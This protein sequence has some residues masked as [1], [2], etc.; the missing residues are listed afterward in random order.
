MAIQLT[1]ESDGEILLVLQKATQG[2]SREEIEAT[3]A[4]PLPLRTLQRTLRRLIEI[5]EITVSG[6][7]RATRYS[8][9]DSETSASPHVGR[10]D[11]LPLSPLAENIRKLV[12]LPLHQRK[13]VGY[14][15]AF[16]ES[17][18]PNQTHYLP[19]KERRRLLEMASS[20]G[21]ELPA[22]T[23]ARQILN[24]LLIDL[25]WNSSRL[26][27]NTYSLLE[28]ERLLQL[29]EIAEGK[30]AREA[31]MIL[32][33]KAAIE[34]LV[35]D[36]LEIGFNRYTIL[37]LHG[38]LAENLMADP[39]A[40]GKLRERPVA[41]SGTVFHPLELPQLIE[42]CFDQI[43]LTA[44]QIK[45][46]LEQSFF[47]MVH[48]P[49]LQPFE[50]VNKRVSRL[51][52]NIPFI[53]QNLCPLSFLEVPVADY[54]DSM[55]CV[56]ELNRVEPLR[57]IF[58]WAYER[59]C[60]QYSALRTSL[61]DPDPFRLRYREQLKSTIGHIIRE[62]MDAQAAQISIHREAGALPVEHRKRFVETVAVELQSLHAGNFARYRVRPSQFERWH[63]L[64]HKPE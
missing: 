5:G 24:R 63:Q 29:G 10:P 45:D 46:P 2:L 47:A 26:E 16:L 20:R 23:Y 52:A 18:V 59:S 9:V 35:E 6:R 38:V 50:D 62:G 32:N 15:R 27:G 22:G 57:E 56:Y 19:E 49:Y 48:L 7:G 42:E 40:A 17:Y 53:R 64:W 39:D 36:A 34:L 3:L 43:L 1:E 33:H 51:A 25:A 44:S 12:Q 54:V 14:N 41:I 31:Q 21:P 60:A 61:G 8:A 37:N 28:T 55:I 4:A 30:E 13:P 11:G 58:I